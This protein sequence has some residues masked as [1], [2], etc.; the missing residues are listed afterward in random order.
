MAA[1]LLVGVTGCPSKETLGSSAIS[2]LSEGVINDPRNKSL[3]FDILKFGL[4]RFC[5]EMTNR[6]APLKLQDDNPVLGRFF[7]TNCQARVVDDEMRKSF[8]V[9]YD[10]RGYAWTNVSQR[11]GFTSAG[12]IEYAP[13]FQMH[14]DAMYIYFRP[15]NVDAIDFKT[16]IVESQLAQTGA[17]MLGVDFNAMGRNIVQ[18]QLQRGFTVVRYSSNGE[19]DFGLGY[20]PLGQKPFKPFQIRSTG[21]VTLANDRTE[22]HSQQHDFIGAFQVEDDD[23]AFYLTMTLDGAPAVDVLLV[24][25]GVGDLMIQ[26]YTQRGGPTQLTASPLLDEPLMPGM[27]YRR[28]VK[29]RKGAYYLILDHSAGI[30]RSAPPQTVGDDRAAKIDYAVQLGDEP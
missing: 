6:G 3:R 24:P 10:G 29:V 14:D 23:Q 18:S 22:V 13:D 4:D 1:A 19:T 12:L 25:K 2:V 7:A 28:Y 26:N 20:I 30:G 27:Q 8:V 16:L 21:R 17:T 9:Q 5:F 15:K 11:I